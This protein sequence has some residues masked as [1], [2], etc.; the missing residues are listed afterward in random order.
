MF[1]TDEKVPVTLDGQDII[2]IKEKMDLATDAKVRE[3]LL[4]IGGRTDLG[5]GDNAFGGVSV[6]MNLSAWL[7]ALAKHNIVDWEGPSFE[8]MPCT[9]HNIGRLDP[10]D[11]LV[12][13]VLEEI[14]RRNPIT[15]AT[16][17]NSNGAAGSKNSRA[18]S[19]AKT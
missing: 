16:N 14:A 4:R 18:R 10:R 5:N 11:P 6:D 1:V 17:P 8:G 2:Y 13:K 7:L 15:R 3:A 9:P 19:K 12:D